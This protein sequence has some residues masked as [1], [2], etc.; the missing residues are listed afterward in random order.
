MEKGEKVKE[1]SSALI[2]YDT[3]HKIKHNEVTQTMSISCTSLNSGTVKILYL[4]ETEEYAKRIQHTRPTRPVRWIT[5]I[6]TISSTYIRA[7]THNVHRL[8]G[9]RPRP[10]VLYFPIRKN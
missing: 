1:T 2:Y 5:I 3:Y 8:G 9:G 10:L 6:I 7:H 4:H